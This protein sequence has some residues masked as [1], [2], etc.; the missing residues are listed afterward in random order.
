MRKPTLIPA[1]G[2]LVLLV[3]FV[4][5]CSPV[6][7]A[8]DPHML[9][10]V[11]AD[12]TEVMGDID[13]ASETSP[14]V[15]MSS[16]PFHYIGISPALPRLVS[17]GKPALEAIVSEIEG[18]GEDGLREYLLAIAGHQIIGVTEPGSSVG[19]GK[20]WARWYRSQQETR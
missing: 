12:I 20:A 15:G 8:G 18:S 9:A 16:N 1:A 4:A 6:T 5:A 11:R 13:R 3:G 17:R 2:L 14:G 7:N 10:L 19:S